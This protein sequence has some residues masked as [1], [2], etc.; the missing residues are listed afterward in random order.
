MINE[1]ATKTFMTSWHKLKILMNFCLI[2]TV[3]VELVD[4]SSGL[5]STSLAM[6]DRYGCHINNQFYAEGSQV[7]T[8]F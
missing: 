4:H 2:I 7:S 3:P 5:H 8:S 1:L 6:P